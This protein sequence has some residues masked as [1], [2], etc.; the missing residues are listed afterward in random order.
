MSINFNQIF[1][2][3]SF[4]NQTDK[5]V[6]DICWLFLK[7][8]WINWFVLLLKWFEGNWT[9]NKPIIAWRGIFLHQTLMIRDKNSQTEL[10]KHS[11]YFELIFFGKS[12]EGLQVNRGGGLHSRQCS[13]NCQL[14]F[15]I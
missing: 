6:N 3:T 9:T 10:K 4:L 2:E 5:R 14:L 8:D 15:I 11:Q 12:A 1:R 7:R 13:T